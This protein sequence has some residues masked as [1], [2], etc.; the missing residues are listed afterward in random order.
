MD[1]WNKRKV[2]ELELRLESRD[3]KVEQLEE[4]NNRLRKK[5]SGERVCSE[6]C[7]KCKYGICISGY[8]LGG[9]YV[10]S[11][12]KCELDNKCKDFM[13]KD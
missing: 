6:V 10:Q 7:G 1:F 3:S 9:I 12:Y 8:N 2:R 5:I 11:Y 13:R 4:E